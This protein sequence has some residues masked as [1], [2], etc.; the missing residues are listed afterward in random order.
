MPFY[1]SNILICNFYLRIAK[2][3][4]KTGLYSEAI[5]MYQQLLQDQ[6]EYI[7]AIVGKWAWLHDRVN[8]V[9]LVIS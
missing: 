9:F 6:P 1:I 7:P 3:E 2:I 4:E 5:E 8:F